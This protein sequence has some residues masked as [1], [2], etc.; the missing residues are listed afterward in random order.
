MHKP[1]WLILLFASLTLMPSR[2]SFGQAA[3]AKREIQAAIRQINESGERRDRSL[4]GKWLTRDFQG[5]DVLGHVYNRTQTKQRFIRLLTYAKSLR[6]RTQVQSVTVEDGAA[7]VRTKEYMLAKFVVGRTGKIHTVT[8]NDVWRN[9]WVKTRDGW[10]LKRMK[11]L[12]STV[13]RDGVSE[14]IRPKSK[15]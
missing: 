9:L 3:Q 12:S 2:A 4:V 14:V 1:F 5:Q 11:Q 13:T 7:T 8:L 10:R 6:L 15:P